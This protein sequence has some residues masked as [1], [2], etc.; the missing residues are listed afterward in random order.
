M[1]RKL[2]LFLLHLIAYLESDVSASENISAY[3]ESLNV[4]KNAG[5]LAKCSTDPFPA[6]QME[7]NTIV[8][9]EDT[10]SISRS[11]VDG[12]FSSETLERGSWTQECEKRSDSKSLLT[13][14]KVERNE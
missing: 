3:T 13:E 8:V 1:L 6:S 14:E 10:L 9:Q 12:E 11:Q 7:C 5:E 2:Q 4:T